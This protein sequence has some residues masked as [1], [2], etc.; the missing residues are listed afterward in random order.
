LLLPL[1][2]LVCL[3]WVESGAEEGGD[4]WVELGEGDGVLKV[5]TVL[6]CL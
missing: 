6:H 3:N 2:D 5:Y 1:S 4:P